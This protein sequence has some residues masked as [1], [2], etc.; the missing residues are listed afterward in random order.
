[1][2][3]Y[4]I[5][6]IK[7]VVFARAGRGYSTQEVDDFIEEVVVTIQALQ[8][9]KQTLMQKMGVL[10]DRIEEYRAQEQSIQNALLTAQRTADQ[11]VREAKETADSLQEGSKSQIDQIEQE[12]RRKAALL[13][14]KAEEEYEAKLADAKV[15]TNFWNTPKSPCIR[16]RLP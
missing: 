16:I 1:M 2:G 14:K 15:R 8:M 5:D 6:D 10:A 9:E 12:A 4:T 11:L 7:N 13:T 3:M